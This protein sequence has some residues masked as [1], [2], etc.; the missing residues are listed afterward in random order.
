[1]VITQNK[2][3]WYKRFGVIYWIITFLIIIFLQLFIFDN[4]P[5]ASTYIIHII[6]LTIPIFFFICLVKNIIK[7]K[8]NKTK[9]IKD[10]KF[11]TQ[12]FIL[13]SLILFIIV[14]IILLSH[15][16]HPPHNVTC[17]QVGGICSYGDCEEGYIE[18]SSTYC[19]NELVC[20]LFLG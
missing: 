15:T 10:W 19:E 13:L 18:R 7:N 12:L 6:F 14:A 16:S 3:V 11:W 2:K 1:M 4:K 20:C 9:L 8:Q 5:I 17:S